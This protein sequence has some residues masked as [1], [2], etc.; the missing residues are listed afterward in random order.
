VGN[1]ACAGMRVHFGPGESFRFHCNCG[2]CPRLASEHIVAGS[3]GQGRCSAGRLHARSRNDRSRR[4][5]N[6]S[7]DAYALDAG[8][9]RVGEC[10]RQRSDEDQNADS[11]GVDAGFE[12]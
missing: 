10:T 2:R 5:G 11:F 9:L 8:L 12:E 3:I 1:A 4:V 6:D 7:V